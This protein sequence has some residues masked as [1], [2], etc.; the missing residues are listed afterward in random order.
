MQSIWIIGIHIPQRSE[1]IDEVQHLLTKFGCS[2][3]TRVGLNN[4]SGNEPIKGGIILLE[5]TGD[6]AEF[7]KLEKAL[8]GIAGLEVK[9]MI[10]KQV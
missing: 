8:L 9:N 4:P 7:I 5:L 10:F 3:R 1:K 6:E 2:I